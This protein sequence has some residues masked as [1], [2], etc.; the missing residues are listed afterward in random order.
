M[1]V[2]N[3][4]VNSVCHKS[5]QGLGASTSPRTKFKFARAIFFAFFF[6]LVLIV[7]DLF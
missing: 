2:Q 1:S 5:D 7:I 6:T 4:Y 3:L